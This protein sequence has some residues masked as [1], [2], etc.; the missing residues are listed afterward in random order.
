MLNLQK[1]ENISKD[2]GIR[3][4]EIMLPHSKIIGQHFGGISEIEVF[5]N[6]EKIGLLHSNI[7]KVDNSTLQYMAYHFDRF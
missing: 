5:E 7:E 3:D 2:T 1:M 4:A 6:G